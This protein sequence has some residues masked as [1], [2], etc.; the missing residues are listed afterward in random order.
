MT[1]VRGC[2]VVGF[3]WFGWRLRDEGEGAYKGGKARWEGGGIRRLC[4]PLVYTYISRSSTQSKTLHFSIT[5]TTT[6]QPHS[7]AKTHRINKKCRPDLQTKQPSSRPST[8]SP[9]SVPS[10]RS[11]TPPPTNQ[12]SRPAATSS[13]PHACGPGS[14]SLAPRTTR[15]R[16]A[17]PFS[18]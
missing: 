6:L 11:P 18:S 7:D 2:W 5:Y 1:G 3:F 13:A 16:A 15:V 8:Q 12:P 10:A 4:L 17:A 9:S 14:P